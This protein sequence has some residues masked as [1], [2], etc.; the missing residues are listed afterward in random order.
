MAPMSETTD[1]RRKD[2]TGGSRRMALFSL[3]V[4]SVLSAAEDGIAVGGDGADKGEIYE[5]GDQLREAAGSRRK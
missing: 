2:R 4:L 3:R 5:G 1:A